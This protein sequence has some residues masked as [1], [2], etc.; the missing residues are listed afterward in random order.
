M[1]V[2]VPGTLSRGLNFNSCFVCIVYLVS[3]G[4]I[5]AYLN[6][7]TTVIST[8][9]CIDYSSLLKNVI[10]LIFKLH[11]VWATNEA[12]NDNKEQNIIHHLKNKGK[13]VSTRKIFEVN[14]IYLLYRV[15]R[16]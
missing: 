1:E 11:C 15:Y 14:H 7:V 12:R 8:C 2:K 5:S 9:T 10:C 4:N 6:V 3:I 16:A 13:L